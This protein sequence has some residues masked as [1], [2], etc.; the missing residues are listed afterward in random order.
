ME[1]LI[2]INHDIAFWTIVSRVQVDNLLSVVQFF[3]FPP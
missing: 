3:V 1:D 2:S